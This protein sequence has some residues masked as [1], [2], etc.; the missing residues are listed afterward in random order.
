MEGQIG[1]FAATQHGE[2]DRRVSK[3]GFVHRTG[4]PESFR[5]AIPEIHRPVLSHRGGFFYDLF[6]R[7]RDAELGA[8]LEIFRPTDGSFIGRS[9]RDPERLFLCHGHPD[10]LPSVR[11][12]STKLGTAERVSYTEIRPFHE[13]GIPFSATIL[14][15]AFEEYGCDRDIRY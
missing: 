14:L 1:G 7:S 3:S 5:T 4:T 2:R 13:R 9:G 6:L 11:R 15:G 8:D 12:V 10:L